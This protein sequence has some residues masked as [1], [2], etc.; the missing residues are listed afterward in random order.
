MWNRSTGI[1][2]VLLVFPIVVSVS[3]FLLL[4][5]YLYHQPYSMEWYQYPFLAKAQVINEQN[6]SNSIHNNITW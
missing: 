1:S 5:E 6:Y 3:F 4:V 2:K